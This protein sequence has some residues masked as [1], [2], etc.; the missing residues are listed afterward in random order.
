MRKTTSSTTIKWMFGM[1]ATTLAMSTWIGEC[2]AEDDSP[3]SPVMTTS[4]DEWDLHTMSEEGDDETGMDVSA[5][6]CWSLG[7][8]DRLHKDDPAASSHGRQQVPVETST[9]CKCSGQRVLS[10]PNN[11][12]QDVHHMQVTFFVALFLFSSSHSS[13]IMDRSGQNALCNNPFQAHSFLF[14]IYP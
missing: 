5:C 6:R 10:V 2:R 9:E 7:V 14:L 4:Q 12:P 8:T 1:L 3:L 11:L 13:L